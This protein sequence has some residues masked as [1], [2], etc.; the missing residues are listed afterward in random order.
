VFA[1]FASQNISTALNSSQFATVVYSSGSG[2]L[3]YSHS[4]KA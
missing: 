2:K 4:H 1:V 3:Y